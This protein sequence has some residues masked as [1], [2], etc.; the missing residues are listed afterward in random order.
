MRLG[1]ATKSGTQ[2]GIMTE[3]L[4]PL[5]GDVKV[6]DESALDSG[7]FIMSTDH[8]MI[9]DYSIDSI[10]EHDCV[11]Q[12]L[13]KD[14]PKTIL[15]EI[16]LYPLQHD[17]RLAW[18]K[19][20]VDE[21]SSLLPD[22]AKEINQSRE[23]TM[24]GDVWVIGA[25]SGGPDALTTLLTA[26]PRLPITIIIAQHIGSDQGSIS[27]QTVLNNRQNNWHVEIASDGKQIRPGHA[28]IVQRNTVVAIEGERLS[29]KEFIHP[30]QA[31]PYINATIRS[32]RRSAQSGMGVVILSGLGDDG[33]SAL[34]EV[35][36][37]T[38][39][40]LAQEDEADDKCAARSMP[41][42]ARAAGVVDESLSASKI[43]RRIAKHYGVGIL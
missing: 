4:Q 8:I 11:M 10:M 14:E 31:S 24:G 6:Y 25:S 1:I 2:A 5:F 16:S 36:P 27:L 26:L 41:D 23:A 22:L 15:S 37:K 9:I 38:I 35:K 29:V 12:M 3:L 30:A 32:V 13:D 20:I 18:R 28:Y 34:K 43:G 39:M 42:A 33:T 21:I 40:V 19:K 7:E 17:E